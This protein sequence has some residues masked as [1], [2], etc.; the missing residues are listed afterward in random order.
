MRSQALFT[1]LS[2]ICLVSARSSQHVGKRLPPRPALRT[3][4]YSSVNS[5]Q[6]VKRV[7]EYS[8]L[9]A[10]TTKYV[11]NGTAI[12][13]VDFDIG[14]SY[15]GLMPIT[16]AANET[17][18][19]YFWFF[20][21]ENELAGDE[22]TI[23]LNGGPGCSSLEGLLQENGPFI[24][25]PGTY[26]P[27][28]N[29]YTWVNLTNM[30]W[31]EQPVGTGF[32]QGTPTAQNEK[33]VAEQFM[34]FFK[35]FVDT[36]GLHGRKVFITGESYAGYYV[37][38]IAYYMLESNDTTYYNLNSIMIYDPSTSSD[39]VQQEMPAV[40]FADYWSTLM[41]FN[42]SF[43]AEL[44]ERADSCGYTDFWNEYLVWPA[45][46][47]MPD[48]PEVVSG[49]DLWDTIYYAITEINPCFNI[50]NIMTYCPVLWD[51]LGFPGSFDYVP[52]GATIYFNRSDVQSAINAPQME[53]S[54][55]TSIDVFPNGD[56]SNPSGLSI[57]PSVIE[58]ANHT[59]IGHGIAD[60]I[61]IA[62]GT[63]LMIQNMTWNGVLGFESKPT[64]NFFVPYHIDWSDSTLAGAGDMGIAHTERGLTYVQVELSGH[65]VP[66]YQPSAAYRMMEFMLGRIG[67][68]SQEGDFTTQTGNYTGNGTWWRN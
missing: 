54:E 32:S 39:S 58:R 18:E 10:N 48:P 41:P 45:K 62:N 51:V 26:K 34:G 47:V 21:S 19:L 11:V 43:S 3:R 16:S 65:M 52:E 7:S 64:E 37:P 68:L 28:Q 33:D 40:P 67:S 29:P 15:A 61:L 66:Q 27:V 24:W 42:D 55:C 57:L 13:D 4:E 1:F 35:N 30:V 38:Y 49:C 20:P 9:N 50:Y 6:P 31:V 8:Y 59:I 46:G 2:S 36:F 63:L 60:F 14:E 23:W 17:R 12:P 44:H 56:N 25:Q 22:I 53:W 5:H